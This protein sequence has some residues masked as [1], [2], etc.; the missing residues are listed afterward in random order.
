MGD[1][2]QIKGYRMILKKLGNTQ[3][4]IPAIGQGT[5]GSGSYLNFN[6]DLVKRRIEVL[7]YGID[8]GMSWLDT[9]D[10]YGGGL[11]EEIVGKIIKGRRDKV[12]VASKFN[13][14]ENTYN[15]VISSVESSLK[16]MGTDYLDLYQLHWPNPVLPISEIMKALTMLV[17]Q[18]Q[19]QIHW[20]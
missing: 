20:G 10:L 7:T 14:K 11:A 13:P 16:R 9:A 4:N 12:F 17:D 6:P 19:D 3:V 18:R 2:H 5:T 8:I 1:Q 15:S